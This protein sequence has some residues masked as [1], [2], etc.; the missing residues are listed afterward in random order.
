SRQ[1]YIP[2]S[3][4]YT[5]AVADQ[6]CCD[7]SEVLLA[8]NVESSSSGNHGRGS[9]LENTTDRL[10]T[11]ECHLLLSPCLNSDVELCLNASRQLVSWKSILRCIGCDE[12]GVICRVP[13]RTQRL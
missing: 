11:A 2:S 10:E 9:R 1:A 6:V 5:C 3:V 7:C 4:G 12:H 8:M 13:I